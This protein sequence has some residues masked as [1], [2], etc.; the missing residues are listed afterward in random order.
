MQTVV[1]C[2]VSS[3]KKV[4]S[5]QAACHSTEIKVVLNPTCSEAQMSSLLR[6]TML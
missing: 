1:I 6:I 5:H 3:G 2:D 4:L